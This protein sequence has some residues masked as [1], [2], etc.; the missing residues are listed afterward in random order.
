MVAPPSQPAHR[1]PECRLVRRVCVCKI[2]PQLALK[3]RLILVMH[4]SEWRKSSNTGHLARLAVA[5]T[6]VRLHGLPHEPVDDSG[7]DPSGSTLVLFPG[8]GAKTLT[9]EV[10]ADLA[11]PVTLLIPDGTWPQAKTMM[12]RVPLLR[13]AIPVALPGPT[14]D[15]QRPRRNVFPDRMS[16]CEAIAQALGCLEGG[17]VEAQLLD[18]FRRAVDRMLMLRGKMRAAD[19]YGGLSP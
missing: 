4:A 11:R 19:V 14:L 18:F 16:T 6:E 13:G 5:G 15:L 7:L 3:T 17:T 8:F 12:R 2:A 9:P 1:C 10:V